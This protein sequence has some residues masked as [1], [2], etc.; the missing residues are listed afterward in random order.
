MS[1]KAKNPLSLEALCLRYPELKLERRKELKL[2]NKYGAL[3]EETGKVT[4][5]HP[6]FSSLHKARREAWEAYS[7][8]HHFVRG[9]LAGYRAKEKE[10]L[11]SST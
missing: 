10:A 2:L 8:Q 6:R 1:S 7:L 9:M 3:R 4:V 11:V 5:N